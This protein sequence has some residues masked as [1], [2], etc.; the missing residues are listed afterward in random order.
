[1]AIDFDTRSFRTSHGREPKGY[2]S[3]AFGTERSPD[4][5]DRD[6]CWFTPGAMTYGN[7]RKWAKAEAARRFGKGASGT[8]YVLS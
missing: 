6:K 7:A 8:L 2:G 1:M 3:W 5:Q 4:T